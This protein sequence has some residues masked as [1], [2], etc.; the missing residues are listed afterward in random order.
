MQLI[1]TII[2]FLSNDTKINAFVNILSILGFLITIWIFFDVR[3]IK[4][5]YI[6]RVRVPQHVKKL[7]SHLSKV[8]ELMNDYDGMSPQI[9]IELVQIEVEL[10]SLKRKLDRKN[11]Q[12]IKQLI[13]EVR[14]YSKDNKNLS[15]LRV[16]YLNLL[17]SIKRIEGLQEDL[18]WE[19]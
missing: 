17:K 16:I 2:N 9:D 11:A 4:N 5:Y 8:A 19:K 13:A 10:E 15:Y 3:N 14:M 7:G 1:D 6:F 12:P 18:R